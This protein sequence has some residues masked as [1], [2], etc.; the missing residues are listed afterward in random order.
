MATA[1]TIENFLARK[2]YLHRPSCHHCKL[3]DHNLVIERIALAAK[4][5]AVW[6]GDHANV[7]GRQL[8]DLAERAMNI[9]RRLRRTPERQ[10]VIRI[11]ITDSRMLLHRQVGIA[12]VE[13][14]ILA[15]QVSFRKAFL[16]IAKFQ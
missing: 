12:L 16:D 13:E 11:E 7:T 5:A 2:C 9:V 1:V 3:A 15:N 4:A 8:R 10:L 14:S 6:R